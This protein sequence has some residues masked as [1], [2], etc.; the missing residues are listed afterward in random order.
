MKKKLL[1]L[2]FPLITLI[3]EI[4]PYGAICVFASGPNDTYKKTFSYFDLTPFGY[5]NFFPLLTALTTCVILVLLTV[6]LLTDKTALIKT[7][8][9]LV[10]VGVA[11]SLCPLIYGFNY[12]STVAAL[13]T[14]S[15][16]F[17]LILLL[18]TTKKSADN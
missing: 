2:L 16:I 5:A 17:E 18:I 4:L 3:L 12:Y 11:L 10:C 14:L 1:T 15:L 9:V 7:T 8:K 6:Y 13:I